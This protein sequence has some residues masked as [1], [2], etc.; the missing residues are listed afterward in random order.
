MTTPS[1]GCA[2]STHCDESLR[3]SDH[4][5]ADRGGPAAVREAT[6]RPC[7]CPIR[8]TTGWPESEITAL[9]RG[10]L[11][12]RLDVA[13][14]A[15]RL[16]S[17]PFPHQVRVTVWVARRRP[18]ARGRVGRRLPLLQVFA[19]TNALVSGDHPTLVPGATFA[20]GF[21]ATVREVGVG[22]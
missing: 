2:S 15:D 17:F 3:A 5:A 16:R 4:L 20:A 1:G 6:P 18:H 10:G 8:G 11:Q 19:P 12:A 21:T 9:G 14:H 13:A 7:C 22:R